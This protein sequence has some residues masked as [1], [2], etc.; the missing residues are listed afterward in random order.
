[1][2]SHG[3]ELEETYPGLHLATDGHWASAV[4]SKEFG[5]LLLLSHGDEF[6]EIYP[7]LHLATEGH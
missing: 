6:E 3:D 5:P 1:L 7:G 2:L 4:P